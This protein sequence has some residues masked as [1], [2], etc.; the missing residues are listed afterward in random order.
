MFS[1]FSNIIAW[2]FVCFIQVILIFGA[3][4]QFDF[5]ANAEANIRGTE[6]SNRLFGKVEYSISII[7]D[8]L[9]F[10]GFLTS[11]LAIAFCLVVFM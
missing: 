10:T 3:Y 7:E 8:A 5:A 6:T 4:V 2:L 1:H 11:V 9:Y